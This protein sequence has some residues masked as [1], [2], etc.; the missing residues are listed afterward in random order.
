MS[1]RELPSRKAARDA[2]C[3]RLAPTIPDL[4]SL[5]DRYESITGR[6]GTG[7]DAVELMEAIDGRYQWEYDPDNYY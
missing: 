2:E 6:T 5:Q 3:L 4:L 7:L 1:F